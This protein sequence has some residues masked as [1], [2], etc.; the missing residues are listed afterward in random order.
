MLQECFSHKSD[1][2]SFGPPQVGESVV[3]LPEE[4]ISGPLFVIGLTASHLPLQQ[5]E[6]GLPNRSILTRAEA[7]DTWGLAQQCLGPTIEVLVFVPL[8]H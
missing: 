4:N 3:S 6:A 2:G 7:P 1:P 8:A 5:S